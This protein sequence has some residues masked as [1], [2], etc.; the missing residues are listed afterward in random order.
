V[1]AQRANLGEHVGLRLR[2]LKLLGTLFPP[3]TGEGFS[4][5]GFDAAGVPKRPIEYRFHAA[6]MKA[7]RAATTPGPC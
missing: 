7:K 4:Q 1:L 6:S 2:R 5:V 3:D